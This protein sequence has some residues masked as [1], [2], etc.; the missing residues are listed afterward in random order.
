M[1]NN[2]VKT[3]SLKQ[4]KAMYEAEILANAKK[5]ICNDAIIQLVELVDNDSAV[6]TC[7][8]ARSSTVLN[9]GCVVECLVKL[10]LKNQASAKKYACNRNDITLDG[11]GYEIKY[12]NSVAY[13]SMSDK[14]REDYNNKDFK[15]LI[16]VDPNGVYVSNT[17]YY[18]FGK[19]GKIVGVSKIDKTLVEW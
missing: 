7:E 8:L 10:W 12:T 2:N 6:I 4:I 13:A 16:L 1:S 19:N 18:L 17:K 3:M 5:H 14:Q 15:P 9:R 11:V